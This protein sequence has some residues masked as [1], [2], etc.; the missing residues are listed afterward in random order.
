MKMNLKGCFPYATV[1]F[2]SCETLLDELPAMDYCVGSHLYIT[3][4]ESL[5]RFVHVCSANPGVTYINT[6]QKVV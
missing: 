4:R 1:Y 2:L 3:R 6:H 5:F